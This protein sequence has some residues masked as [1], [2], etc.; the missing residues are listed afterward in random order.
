MIYKWVSHYSLLMSCALSTCI[1]SLSIWLLN[2]K[3]SQKP[4]K[5]NYPTYIGI[6]ILAFE[7]KLDWLSI[8]FFP[9]V[10]CCINCLF[11]ILISQQFD[12]SNSTVVS[13]L[14]AL[15]FTIEFIILRSFETLAQSLVFVST[16]PSLSNNL[17]QRPI[18]YN[19]PLRARLRRLYLYWVPINFNTR[20]SLH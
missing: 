10:P 11:L 19:A 13:V 15:S 7:Q 18:F 6:A 3:H 4:C 12:D 2:N 16:R 20:Y 1:F 9:Q 8:P 17:S 5:T 14:H